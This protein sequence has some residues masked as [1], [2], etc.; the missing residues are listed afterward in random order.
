MLADDICLGN[1]L[2]QIYTKLLKDCFNVYSNMYSKPNL[3][4]DLYLIEKV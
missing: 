1:I 2:W 3:A 4:T